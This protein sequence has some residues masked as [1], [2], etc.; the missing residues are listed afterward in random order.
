MQVSLDKK[1]IPNTDVKFR[2]RLTIDNYAEESAA[3][4]T[5]RAPPALQALD[6]LEFD[7]VAKK[8]QK[9]IQT[10]SATAIFEI[11]QK[12]NAGNKAI[13]YFPSSGQ[14]S[15]LQNIQ[16]GT[17]LIFDTPI[18]SVVDALDTREGLVIDRNFADKDG[19]RC[20]KTII[21]FSDSTWNNLPSGEKSGLSTDHIVG[22]K[23][24][25]SITRTK[26]FRF[27]LNTDGN[28]NIRDQL[29]R[30]DNVHDIMV[31]GYKQFE[32]N[33]NKSDAPRYYMIDADARISFNLDEPPPKS[34]S[35]TWFV[36][37][38][39]EQKT[40]IPRNFDLNDGK[41]FIFFCTAVRYIQD[42]DTGEWTGDWIQKNS[43]GRPILAVNRR[44]K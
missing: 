27:E 35:D 24:N 5:F 23:D 28:K 4:L 14:F 13:V 25:T 7:I 17:R 33:I 1:I 16:K 6:T 38:A 18:G 12:Q 3:E 20:L 43:R 8:T 11:V 40:N 41:N 34:L 44:I 30:R 29:I 9:A 10:S 32:D 39:G 19:K 36:N 15:T 21:K 26:R 42:K 37:E 22:F 2:V 31:F